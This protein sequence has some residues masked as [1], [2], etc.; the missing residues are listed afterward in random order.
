VTAGKWLEAG[1]VLVPTKVAEAVE[2][3]WGLALEKPHPNWG[4]VSWHAGV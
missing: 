4:N 2:R 3:T 1:A